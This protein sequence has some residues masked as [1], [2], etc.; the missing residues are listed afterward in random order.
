MYHLTT[1]LTEVKGIG[2]MLAS[3]LAKV[4]LATVKDF[5]LWLPLRYEDRSRSVTISQ[6]AENELVTLQAK[7]ISKGNYYR[8]RRSMQNA[9]VEDATGRLKLMW[10]NNAYIVDRLVKDQEYLFSG[11]I[12]DR[13]VMLQPIVENIGHESI[14]TNRLVPLYSVMPA[15]KQG[16]LRRILKHI[17]DFLQPPDDVV[18]DLVLK[19]KLPDLCTALTQL[20]FPDTP[21]SITTARERLAMEEL[22]SLMDKSQKIKKEWI[23]SGKAP[24]INPDHVFPPLPFE[25]TTAQ[26]RV[27]QE[28]MADIQ[29][30]IP[31]NRLLLGDV[32][33]GKTVVAGLAA[34][35]I[36]KA[37][38]S[39]A[40]IVPTRI[41]AEQHFS[42]LQQ[43][44]PHL[45]VELMTTAN[46]KNSPT[47][48][49]DIPRLVIGTHTVINRLDQIKPGLIIYDEQ[50]RFGVG[51]RSYQGTAADVT[52]QKISLQPHILTMSATP[53]P[54][55]LM[56]TI[57]SHLSLSVIDELP[58]GRQ[59]TKT[60]V[61][62]E[63]KRE[64]AIHWMAEQLAVNQAQQPAT[65][66][67]LIVC[68]FIDPSRS[69]ALENVAAVTQTYQHIQEAFP[70]N[71]VAI[72]H[73]RMTKAEQ[74]IVTDKL[75][76]RQI[77]VLVTT[78]IVEVGVDLPAASI[79]VIEAADR[80]GLASLHQL[81]G[82]VGRA[83]QQAYCL[84]FSSSGQPAVLDRLTKFSTISNGQQLADLDLENRGA[85][86]IFGTQQH[87]FDQL[88]FASWTN[89]ELITLAR[90]TFERVQSIS[91]WKPF[92]DMRQ[93]L[94]VTTPLAN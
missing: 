27:T 80:F 8:G 10:F 45:V 25:L 54:R 64:S 2:P 23:D 66:Q 37:G 94:S 1:P 78:P 6:L 20:H 16:T 67:A 17:L 47:N 35:Q 58:R 73:G 83:G 42:T 56:L 22:L 63:T 44:F 57:F 7:V 89:L 11:K 28:I 49:S 55:S 90:T 14:H 92:F 43:I 50:H 76:S 12:N 26:Q 4:E 21:E 13:G 5:L 81:R 72:L 46:K 69:E 51:Q 61:V 82:R 84:V 93:S 32:G 30:S 19:N 33:S 36:I 38:H 52:G 88:R 39:V 15:I 65:V 75:F 24:S 48:T 91:E 77:E 41:L 34:D 71:R 74:Q 62:P 31:M 29:Q 53:I 79:I 68:P 9:T 86:D 85:G 40:F 70:Q 60:W 3:K 18:N 59:P 87:G